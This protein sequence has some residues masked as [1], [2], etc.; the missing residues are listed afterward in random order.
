MNTLLSL[1]LTA[2]LIGL[3][4]LAHEGARYGAERLLGFHTRFLRLMPPPGPRWKRMAAILAAPLA[5]YV[6]VCLPTLISFVVFGIETG[7]SF[8]RVSTTDPAFDAHGKIQPGDE[9]RQ[10]D[11][12]IILHRQEGTPGRPVQE[13][14]QEQMERHGPPLTLTIVR[15]GKPTTVDVNPTRDESMVPPGYRLGVTLDVRA[16]TR[17]LGLAD[18][19]LVLADPAIRAAR[20]LQ[21]LFHVVV[22]RDQEELTGP[23]GIADML[24]QVTRNAFQNTLDTT[25]FLFVHASVS[26]LLPFTLFR[27]LLLALKRR[28]D[29]TEPV[30]G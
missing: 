23:V 28:D 24:A 18:L 10:I 12:E 2:G 29:A 11:G 7:T 19:D 22:G 1:L 9:L 4:V 13:V 30:N 6:L 27:L 5:T 14:I 21:D 8:Y 16:E 25:T 3:L 15:D 26:S 17:S 20:V